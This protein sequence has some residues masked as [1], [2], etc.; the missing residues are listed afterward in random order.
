MALVIIEWS[1]GSDSRIE[2]CCHACNLPATC[3]R[4]QQDD[5]PPVDFG[6]LVQE[7]DRADHI[8]GSPSRVTF[9]H[10]KELPAE[11]KPRTGSLSVPR[12][13][14]SPLAIARA[15]DDE[16]RRPGPRPDLSH[17][18]QLALCLGIV[19]A[20][21]NDDGRNVRCR[22]VRE[23]KIRCHPVLRPNLEHDIF[24][25]VPVSHMA[26][27]YPCLKRRLLRRGFSGPRLAPIYPLF[28]GSPPLP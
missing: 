12:R 10:E 17:V 11:V 6:P 15:F 23:V 20:R 3:D 25:A 24:E 16:D 21:H 2:R 13:R 22:F 7:I 9:A 19:L 4:S 1:Y 14:F 26:C 8:P 27:G 5:S 28:S 18:V